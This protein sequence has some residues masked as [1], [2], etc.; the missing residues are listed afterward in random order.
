MMATVFGT[1]ISS[2]YDDVN[3]VDDDDDV[4]QVI[5]LERL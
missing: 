5:M 2:L 3:D 4:E 1:F